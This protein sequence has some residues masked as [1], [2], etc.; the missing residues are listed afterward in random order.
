MVDGLLKNVYFFI[1]ELDY[2][3]FGWGFGSFI[4]VCVGVGVV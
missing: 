3:V 1:K 2:L 4:G